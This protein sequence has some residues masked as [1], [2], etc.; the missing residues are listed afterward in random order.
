MESED[1]DRHSKALDAELI[2]DPAARAEREARNGLRQVDAVIE[3]VY[4]T[5]W[6]IAAPRPFS[7]TLCLCDLDLPGSPSVFAVRL[8][9]ELLTLQPLRLKTG[10]I[11][12]RQLLRDSCVWDWQFFPAQAGSDHLRKP[13]PPETGSGSMGGRPP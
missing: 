13:I 3:M 10:F 8:L 7:G 5:R 12:T 11:P 2:S 9:S 1:E 6:N 4:A